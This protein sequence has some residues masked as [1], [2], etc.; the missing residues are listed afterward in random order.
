[1][2]NSLPEPDIKME[3]GTGKLRLHAIYELHAYGFNSL[4]LPT[5]PSYQGRS[6]T[7]FEGFYVKRHF[8]DVCN[9]GTEIEL[10]FWSP[11]PQEMCSILSGRRLCQ[12]LQ[13]EF[14]ED[15]VL[16]VNMQLLAVR[17]N[18]MLSRDDYGVEG[19]TVR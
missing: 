11:N 16:L 17:K 14:Q 9:Y 3:T 6:S 4:S 7:V 15:Y 19:F 2:A 8:S 12:G 5:L 18:G 13:H 10:G 1:M